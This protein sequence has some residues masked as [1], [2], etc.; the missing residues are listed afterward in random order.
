MG[1]CAEH[2]HREPDTA[3]HRQG[4]RRR[5]DHTEPRATEHEPREE[6]ADHH[7]DQAAPAEGEQRSGES[8][9]H[10]DR[11]LYEHREIMPRTPPLVSV[12]EATRSYEAVGGASGAAWFAPTL[13]SST[14]RW[15]WR[16]SP[17]SAPPSIGGRSSGSRAA[18]TWPRRPAVLAVGDLHTENF[19]TW[20][21]AEGRL[22]WGINDFDE[23]FPHAVHQRPRAP[24]DVGASEHR[25]RHDADLPA[26]RMRRHPRRVPLGRRHRRPAVRARGG[27][28][29][30]PW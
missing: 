13:R 11:Q 3:Q 17:F 7:R 30:P 19:G 28:S 6:L 26:C 23:A 14:S 29:G 27:A 22:I 24:R 2:Q 8:R 12:V 16:R 15:R 5:I 10:E 20:R 1:A 25:G 9:E 4:L 21:D 18:A